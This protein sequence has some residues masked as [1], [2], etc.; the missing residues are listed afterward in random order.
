MDEIKRELLKSVKYVIP[1]ILIFLGVLILENSSSIYNFVST[2][3]ST[4][5]NLLAPFFIGFMIA[6]ILNQPMKYLESKFKLKRG[7]SISLIYG[8]LDTRSRVIWLFIIPIIKSNI[9]DISTSIPLGIGQ[10]ETLI[11]NIFSN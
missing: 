5:N 3:I 10:A 9:N 1:I 4:V 11:N 7:I 2:N 6:Y 8:I